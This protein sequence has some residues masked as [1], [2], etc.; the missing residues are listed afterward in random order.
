MKNNT[1]KTK[2]KAV[3]I[4]SGSIVI[5]TTL[6]GLTAWGTQAPQHQ[7]F[8][9]N[10]SLSTSNK[11]VE[12]VKNAKFISM[13]NGTSSIVEHE[14]DNKDHLYMW[15]NNDH[16]QQGNGITDMVNKP[17]EVV[18]LT[19][20]LNTGDTITKISMTARTSSAVVHKLS[21]N[22]D[23][24]YMWGSNMY[25]Q[26]AIGTND[27]KLNMLVPHEITLLTNKL[28]SGD[29]ITQLSTS[30]NSSGLVVHKKDGSDHLY[31]WSINNLSQQ[32]SEVSYAI[33]APT[34]VTTLN[35]YLSSKDRIKQISMSNNTSSAVIHKEDGSEKLFMWG[36]NNFGE[37]GN[38]EKGKNEDNSRKQ[39]KTP[40]EVKVINDIV[41]K[42]GEIKNISM[43]ESTSSAVIHDESGDN[44]YMWGINTAGQQGNG[45]QGYEDKARTVGKVV[46]TPKK[47]QIG[48][49]G[50]TTDD[51]IKQ[52]SMTSW[53][54]SLVVHNHKENKDHLYIWG[55]NSFGQYGNGENQRNSEVEEIFNLNNTTENYKIIG[56]SMS[57][58]N[59]SVLISDGENSALYMSGSNKFGQQGNGK[60]GKDEIEYSP[61]LINIPSTP[62]PTKH[63][64]GAKIAII[65]GATIGAAALASGATIG[66]T[67]LSKKGKVNK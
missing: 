65:A 17:T 14:N 5:G 40:K 32:G 25:G 8:L 53:T 49:E 21:D 13:G 33:S 58:F 43:S 42:T 38:G 10:T 22:K 39:I 3:K 15:G 66:G 57:M 54:S 4:I 24:L 16:G 51:E 6:L 19:K 62:K 12:S 34:E 50:L 29:T 11:D 46:S 26:Q 64:N 41:G 27:Q 67:K 63:S 20:Q 23:H 1:T 7:A 31:M 28:N 9:S 55:D 61:K 59:S 30:E 44:L 56:I 45:E 18:N 48:E 47:V 60:S 52:T 36:D 35:K 2:N 37:Q